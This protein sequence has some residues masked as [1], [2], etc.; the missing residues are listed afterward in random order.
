MSFSWELGSSSGGAR[1]G[2]GWVK[3]WDPGRVSS[4]PL[5]AAWGQPAQSPGFHRS[6]CGL[7]AGETG[8][9]PVAEV[10]IASPRQAKQV[11]PPFWLPG[12]CGSGHDGQRLVSV[13]SVVPGE[14]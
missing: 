12:Q 6:W 5:P 3:V 13:V 14:R 4:L 7:D 10:G 9:G 11:P 8:E 2:W 1:A